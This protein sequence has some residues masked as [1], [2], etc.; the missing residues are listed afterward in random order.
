MMPKERVQPN[1][2][3][4][5]EFTVPTPMTEQ[6][7]APPVHVWDRIA[8]VLDQQDRQKGILNTNSLFNIS[9][10]KKP[11]KALYAAVG[12]TVIAGIVWLLK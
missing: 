9:K 1:P 4:F 2:L 5:K 12:A 7:I 8:S 11:R 10:E 3:S 6:E